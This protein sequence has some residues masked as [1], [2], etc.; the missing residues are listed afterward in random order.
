MRAHAEAASG[1][2]PNSD[3]APEPVCKNENGDIYAMLQSSVLLHLIGIAPENV[4]VVSNPPA[5]T[6]EGEAGVSFQNRID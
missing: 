6:C 4:D 2:P 1:L 3:L 5:G